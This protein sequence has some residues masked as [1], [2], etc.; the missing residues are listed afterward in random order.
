MDLLS[1]GLDDAD[2]D[3]LQ[4]FSL[5]VVVQDQVVA[6]LSVCAAE[7][8]RPHPRVDGAQVVVQRVQVLGKK[9][10]QI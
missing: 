2:H 1:H 9:G 6:L 4:A 7:R 3:V 5:R 8:G 10:F